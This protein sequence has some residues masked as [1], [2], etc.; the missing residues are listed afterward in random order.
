MF[1]CVNACANVC[2][3]VCVSVWVCVCVFLSRSAHL[4]LDMALKMSP[5]FYGRCWVCVS[6]SASKKVFFCEHGR[7]CNQQWLVCH[8]LGSFL[9]CAEP[10]S[11][12]AGV[13]RKWPPTPTPPPPST[14]PWFAQSG[15]Q[16][17]WHRV[18]VMVVPVSGRLREQ[19][20][21][22][23]SQSSAERAHAARHVHVTNT[24][25]RS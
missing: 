13:C 6:V 24:F 21:L 4:P 18:T 12:G 8:A 23:Q 7:L 9:T 22:N 10:W 2:L 15:G 25:L 17:R 1:L 19:G 14:S 3:S 20:K 16:C 5:Q 11:G